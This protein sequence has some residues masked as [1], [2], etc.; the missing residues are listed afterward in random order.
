MPA[1]IRFFVLLKTGTRFY[2]IYKKIKEA[3]LI[4]VASPIYFL[5]FPSQ[6]KLYLTDFSRF[7]IKGS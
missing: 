4:I 5:S 7:I 3:E 2:E 1:E 6:L